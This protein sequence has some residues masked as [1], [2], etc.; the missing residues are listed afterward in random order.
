MDNKYLDDP[1]LNEALENYFN[2]LE[3]VNEG[4]LVDKL[5]DIGIITKFIFTSPSAKK[6]IKNHENKPLYDFLDK[7]K[8]FKRVDLDT[9]KAAYDTDIK[10][11]TRL[12]SKLKEA[13]KSDDPNSIKDELSG[14][15][16]LKVYKDITEEDIKETIKW[17]KNVLLKRTEERIKNKEYKQ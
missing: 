5:K 17:Y 12:I 13:K 6:F 9:C 3:V 10:Y 7:Y 11:L 14:R 1:V 16:V 2:N 8:S 15:P 4:K